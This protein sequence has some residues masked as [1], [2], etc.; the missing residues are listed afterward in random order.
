MAQAHQAVR[1]A[2]EQA[3]YAHARRFLFVEFMEL[4]SRTRSSVVSSTSVMLA[5]LCRGWL[6]RLWSTATT[7]RLEDA[8]Q[9]RWY[10]FDTSPLVLGEYGSY[11]LVLAKHLVQ[12]MVMR[13]PIEGD[14]QPVALMGDK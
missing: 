5:K 3:D 4:N 12:R 7:V 8:F 13:R 14:S 10:Y 6:H 2:E 9:G 11:S 1:T